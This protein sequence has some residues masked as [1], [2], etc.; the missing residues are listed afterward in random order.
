MGR[1][2]FGPGPLNSLIFVVLF[3]YLKLEKSLKT[4]I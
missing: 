2:S 3:Q 1:N 4:A